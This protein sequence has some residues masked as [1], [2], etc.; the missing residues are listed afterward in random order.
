MI[1]FKFLK[2]HSDS[3]MIPMFRS[4]FVQALGFK[5]FGSYFYLF[6]GLKGNNT[7][8]FIYSSFSI[9]DT[10]IFC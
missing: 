8:N 4:C 7:D 5:K 10:L 2:L 1:D 3:M 6:L 9:V